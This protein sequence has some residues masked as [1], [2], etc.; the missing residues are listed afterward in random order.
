[1][2]RTQSDE[3]RTER[4]PNPVVHFEIMGK[5][6]PA[7]RDF[8]QGVFDWKFQLMQGMD[9]G[10]IEAQDGRG[11]GGGI[12]EPPDG[13]SYVTVYLEVDDINR[14]LG[15]VEAKGGKTIMPRTVIPGAV[16]FALF[17][18]PA[19]NVVGLAEPGMPP[20]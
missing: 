19:G 12:G 18:D 1:M 5:D 7:L 10:M 3:E 13:N 8:Y 14:Y 6:G 2:A 4:M 20:A 9:Y 15:Q 11:I 16:V 17:S